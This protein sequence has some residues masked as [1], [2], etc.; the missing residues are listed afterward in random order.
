MTRLAV[1][2]SAVLV[3]CGASVAIDA[4]VDAGTPS[5]DAG[6]MLPADQQAWLDAH[7]QVRRDAMPAPAPALKALTWSTSAQALAE[8]WAG[9]CN[10]MHRDPNALGENLYAATGQEAISVIVGLWASEKANYDY[11]TNGC[12]LARDC[13]HYT[14]LV[15]RDTTKV[16]CAL[17]RCTTGSPLGSGAWYFGV[18]NYDPPGNFIGQKPY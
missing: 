7:N 3:G 11:A 14:Q 1:L 12:A 6:P 13:G 8:D 9:R 15:W 2:C 5:V 16:G 10:F 17:K 18:C 4:G